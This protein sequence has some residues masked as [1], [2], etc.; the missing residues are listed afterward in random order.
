[1]QTEDKMSVLPSDL[2]D[3]LRDKDPSYQF[4]YT[5]FLDP[6]QSQLN[7]PAP[8]QEVDREAYTIE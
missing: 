8:R 1:M 4:E 7:T 3:T 2:N 6:E 5:S